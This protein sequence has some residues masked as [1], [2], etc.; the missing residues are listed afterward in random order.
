M[1]AALLATS[2]AGPLITVAFGIGGGAL[3][4]AVMA[5]ATGA[6]Q[7]DSWA[8]RQQAGEMRTKAHRAPS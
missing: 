2:F 1:S 8:N 6:A 7:R 5:R 4:L 3:L